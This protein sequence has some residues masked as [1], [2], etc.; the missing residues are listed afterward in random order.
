MSGI[1][2]FSNF[3]LE[4]TDISQDHEH[5]SIDAY[6][7]DTSR[8]Q[9]GNFFS[10][11]GVPAKVANEYKKKFNKIAIIKNMEVELEKRGKGIGKKLFDQVIDDAYENGAEAIFLIADANE[12]NKF[13][14]TKWY[15]SY[16]F[17]KIAKTSNSDTLMLLHEK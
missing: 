2:S 11:N 10:S 16:G 15:E 12:D 6:V 13:D 4:T 8:E 3:I 17:E 1:K 9:L 5:G 14:L 7:V